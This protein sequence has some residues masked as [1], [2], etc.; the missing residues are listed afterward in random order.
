MVSRFEAND[1]DFDPNARQLPDGTPLIMRLRVN[2]MIATGVGHERRVL[3][4]VKLTAG[5]IALADHNEAGNLKKRD[6]DG[7]DPFRYFHASLGRQQELGS[8]AVHVTVSGRLFD[9][10]P[11]APSD[12]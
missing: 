4:V 5:Q 6:A 2:D 1:K 3:R 10:G 9:P 8:R 11:S 7:T 12:G